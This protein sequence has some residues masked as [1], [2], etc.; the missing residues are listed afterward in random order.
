L[1]LDLSQGVVH[2]DP[3][4]ASVAVRWRPAVDAGA[5]EA[6]ERRY[7]LVD[8][9]AEG[10]RT[11]RY[12]LTDASSANL[13]A[14]VN[15]PNVVDTAGINRGA[16]VLDAPAWRRWIIALGVTRIVWGPFFTPY[17]AEA[18]LYYFFWIIPLAALVVAWLMRTDRRSPDVVKVGAAALMGI[19]L[20]LFL[21][22]GSLDSRLPDVVVPAAVTGG[23]LLWRWIKTAREASAVWRATSITGL[24]VVSILFW[25]ALTTY[26]R[27]VSAGRL[28]TAG[29]RVASMRDA[30][31]ELGTRPIDVRE[32]PGSPS[33]ASL[34]RY[35][36][37]CTSPEDRLLL[38]AYEPQV[39]YFSERLFAGG[40][41]YFHQRR[42]SSDPE[43]A[44]IVDALRNERVPLVIIEGERLRMLRD[45]YAQVDEYVTTRYVPVMQGT[46]G[47]DRVWHVLA[48]PRRTVTSMRDGLPCYRA[49]S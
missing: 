15:D 42:F 37:A 8:G 39:F 27:S 36:H 18:W 5:R 10:E 21:I 16:A 14:L 45:D 2:L 40:M 38:V 31:G 46:F 3:V 26:E 1:R 25:A 34:I 32:L 30:T 4:R 33:V 22:R 41:A 43:Q 35:V 28:A 24:A 13:R 7:G 20:N 29:V 11:F 47:D 23:F 49:S 44:R 9:G 17:D 19:L 48:D 6:L 12:G